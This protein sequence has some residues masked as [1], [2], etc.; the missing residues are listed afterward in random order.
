MIK[1]DQMVNLRRTRE[2]ERE[3]TAPEVAVMVETCHNMMLSEDASKQGVESQF[4][5]CKE[6]L[7]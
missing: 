3:V 6:G 1:G 5:E 7:I 2:R 4:V